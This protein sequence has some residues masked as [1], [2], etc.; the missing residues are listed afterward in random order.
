MMY[1]V[2]L[3]ISLKMTAVCIVK[4]DGTVI[5]EGKVLS[6]PVALAKALSHWRHE[7]ALIGLEAC[8]LSEWLY[9]GL[10]ESG[11]D[12]R[13]LETRHAQR[14]LS[15]RPNK[16]DR[17]DA[18]GIADMMRLGHYRPVHVK[19]KTAQ[20]IRAIIIG[21]K[22]LVTGIVSVETTIRS[23]LK[24]QGVKLGAT[25]R[26]TFA[27]KVETVLEDIPEL[28]LAVTP[29]LTV[30]NE[31]RKQKAELDRTL[32]RMARQD[33][34]C[35]RLMTVPGVGPITSLAF[36]A[37]ID[38]PAR[39]RSSKAVAAH[40]GLTSRIYQSGEIDRSGG[41][42]KCGDHLMRYYLYEAANSHLRISRRWSALKSWGVKLAGRIGF[43][44]A[45]VAVARKLAIL[46]HRL[47]TKG[48]D[49]QFGNVAKI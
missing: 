29:L 2:G 40:L 47:W 22:K 5:W 24:V 45:C 33:P 37:T 38:D 42:S 26:S 32:G 41:I 9:G 13:C 35:K 18:R 44:K 17:N 27:R 23:I 25:H 31:M 11:F 30:R 46:L 16:T 21:R 39:F 48:E 1:F 34:V 10:V 3:D 6:E 43:K 7:I 20:H 15:T 4:T 19:S 28:R 14:F 12:V 49:F 36:K 8:P